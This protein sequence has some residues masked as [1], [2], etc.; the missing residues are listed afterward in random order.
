MAREEATVIAKTSLKRALLTGCAVA[1]LGA[2]AAPAS[3]GAAGKTYTVIQCDRANRGN[4]N[5]ALSD[6]GSYVTHDACG[7]SGA[8]AVKIDDRGRASHGAWGKARWSTNTSSLGIVAVHGSAKLRRHHGHASRLWIADADQRQTG[9]VGGG[10]TG[11][12]GYH[13][14]RWSTHGHGQ[15][16]FIASLSCERAGGCPGSHQAHTWVRNV[17]LK[18]AD[19]SDPL[20]TTSGALIASGWR[21]GTQDLGTGGSDVG[22]G[23][24]QIVARVD[25]A[26]LMTRNASCASIPGSAFAKTFIPCP[27]RLSL[28]SPSFDTSASP[29][30][31]GH[32]ALSIC[33]IDFAGNRGCDD[34][35]VDVDNT[36]PELAFARSQDGNDPELIKAPV[37][38]AT[39]GVAGGRIYYRA[40]G[41]S[42][43][44]P[45]GTQARSGALEARVDSTAVPPGQYE[46]LGQATD[47]AGNFA[48]TTWRRDGQ[49][50]VLTFPLKSGVR[51]TGYLAPSGGHRKTIRYGR[52]SK[53]R[54]RLTDRVGHPLAVQ[55]VTVVEHFGSGALIDR[56]VRTVETDSRGRWGE[57]IPGGPSRRIT[58]S[59]DGSPR[60]IPSRARVGELAV[61]TR[62]GLRLSRRHVPAGGR[63][64]FKG[65]VRHFAARIPAGGKLIELQV[66]A[67]HSWDTVRHAFYTNANGKYRIRY[68]FAHFYTSNV[69]YRFRLKVLREQGWAYKAPAKSKPR[70]LVVEAR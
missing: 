58:A 21:R 18:V 62:V 65:R 20:L 2:L 61:R 53:V 30:H 42:T 9:R 63:V 51:L 68:R 57:R 13:R 41:A 46:F 7:E 69:R 15:R 17:H 26:D 64:V 34:R 31:D 35:M 28:S 27:G 19:Y 52:R 12:T 47:A 48:Q 29:F 43:W 3:A 23:V 37:S 39:S 55:E 49:P 50:M 14:Y 10:G 1:L 36:P 25:G 67:G 56:R 59:Y 5:A 45:L 44:Q 40:V 4:Q 32:D 33:A 24:R 60:Y 54:G 38:D 16:Q 6:A 70:K 8:Y 22:S 66:K 11:P